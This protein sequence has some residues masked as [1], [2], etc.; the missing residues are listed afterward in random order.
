MYPTLTAADNGASLFSLRH[1]DQ[2]QSLGPV[3]E[4]V[5]LLGPAFCSCTAG[6]VS[7]QVG[8]GSDWPWP[9]LIARPP[10]ALLLDQP[11]CPVWTPEP[12][13]RSAPMLEV[14]R[15]LGVATIYVTHDH[16]EAF[17]SPTS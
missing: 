3:A 9:A 4:L 11:R 2:G 12:A 1:L 14:V 13:R 8:S 6:Q 15:R 7:S 16:V 17:W 5:E 10:R